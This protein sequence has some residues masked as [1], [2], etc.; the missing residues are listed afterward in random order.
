MTQP[1]SAI[2]SHTAARI[3]CHEGQNM[4]TECRLYYL[5]NCLRQPVIA[6]SAPSFG[7]QHH[8]GVLHDKQWLLLS[9]VL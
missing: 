9:Y 3:W 8:F 5:C 1:V 4:I 7:C 2:K 6:A